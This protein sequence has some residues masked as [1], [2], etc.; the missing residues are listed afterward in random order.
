[1]FGHNQ[2]AQALYEKVGYSVTSIT[3]AKQVGAA[4]G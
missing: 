3:M 2:G 4:D 1:M